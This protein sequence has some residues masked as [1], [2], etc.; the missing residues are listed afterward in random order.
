[1]KEQYLD[2]FVGMSH[3]GQVTAAAWATLRS[4]VRAIDKN[5]STINLLRKAQTDLTEPGLAELLVKVS[6]DFH[7]T[8]DFREIQKA[9][10]VFIAQDTEIRTDGT[11]SIEK[12]DKTI[13][14]IIPHLR[15]SVTVILLSQVPVGY[16]RRL[17]GQIETTHPGLNFDL[18]YWVD[19]II[20]TQAIDHFLNPERVI[21]GADREANQTLT[22]A[23][24]LF[25][26]PKLFM[27]YESAE[28]TKA[29]INLYLATSVAFANTLSNFCERLGANM[30][31]II[32]AL[33]LDRRIGPYAYLR[34]SLRIA[35][36]HLER[37]LN[38]LS[39][40][41]EE[42]G[43]N[44]G[45]IDAILKSNKY[46]Y[47]WALLKLEEY[48][49]QY[50]QGVCIWG[51]A[52]KKNTDSTHNAP[53][54]KLIDNLGNCSLAVYDPMATLSASYTQVRQ[55]TDKYEA[56]Q[57]AECLIITTEWDEFKTV[58]LD[59][60]SKEMKGRVIIDCVGALVG[61][62]AELTNFTYIC[63]GE[64]N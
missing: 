36:G 9:K 38:M 37:D 20:M 33:Q 52:Y 22:E 42:R 48:L 18:Y 61:R 21:I 16:T 10:L 55:T 32:P 31:E 60:L 47:L 4:P 8:T 5:S 28:L 23:L 35:G 44:P 3:M 29:A 13:Q 14:E 11:G 62:K 26:C 58:D 6:K 2:T 1:M 59:R 12:L 43:I 25:T 50:G 27:N 53:S 40:L 39:R 24:R 45:I 49:P 41:S 30:S 51:L 64:S 17:K 19:T 56:A 46:R 63:M 54:L 34:P 57:G 15:H 7:P